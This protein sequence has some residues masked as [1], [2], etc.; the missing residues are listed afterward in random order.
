MYEQ[1]LELTGD[2]SR[3]A[4]QLRVDYDPTALHAFRVG[5]RT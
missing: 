4:A 5:I 2:V 1:L 3:D